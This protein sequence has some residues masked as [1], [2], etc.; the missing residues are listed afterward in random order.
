M[1]NRYC[2]IQFAQMLRGL[3]TIERRNIWKGA[4]PP[5]SLL[6]SREGADFEHL[7]LDILNEHRDQARDASLV[8]DFLEKTDLRVHVGDLNR[9]RG[10][11]V[12]VTA[13]LDPVHYQT[14]LAAIKRLE[15]LVMLSP[16]SLAHFGDDNSATVTERA[17]KIRKK[18]YMALKRRHESP[19]GP[20]SSV[21][22]SLREMVRKFV[23]NEATRSTI[24]MRQREAT[25]GVIRRVRKQ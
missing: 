24:A 23:E 18:L 1:L 13:S 19:L 4:T 16:V 14:K 11:R 21:P 15:E 17:S 20:V 8:E 2:S 10:A 22:E 3:E 9:K 5:S 7:M 25:H 6:P 12:Q